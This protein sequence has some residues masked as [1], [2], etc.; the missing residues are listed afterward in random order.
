MTTGTLLI[1]VLVILWGAT[2]LGHTAELGYYPS[3]LSTS[4][5]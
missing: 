5:C 4:Y 2:R 3:G 1:V